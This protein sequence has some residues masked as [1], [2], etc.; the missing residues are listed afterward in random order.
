[1]KKIIN[2]LISEFKEENTGVDSGVLLMMFVLLI[3]V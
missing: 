2:V 1:M 3:Q